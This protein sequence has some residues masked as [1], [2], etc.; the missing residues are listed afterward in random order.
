MSTANMKVASYKA[1]IAITKKYFVILDPDNADRVLLPTADN[2]AAIGYC[3]DGQA[4]VGGHI[5]VATGSGDQ[6]YALAAGVITKGAKLMAASG[7]G[8]KVATT[9]G[10]TYIVGRAEE[11]AASGVLFLMTLDRDIVSY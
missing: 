7:G 1:G 8:V 3:P 4:T 6:V 10:A 2:M 11:A 5:G 9:S